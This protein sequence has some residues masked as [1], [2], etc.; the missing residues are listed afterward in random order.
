MIAFR[1]RQIS[2]R[3]LTAFTLVAIAAMCLGPAPRGASQEPAIV[4]VWPGV[5]P[6]SENRTGPESVR[7]TE[8]GD[9]VVTNVHRP[10]LTVYLPPADRA[11][12]AGVIVMPGGGHRELW[13][14]HEGHTVARWL[15]DRGVA[16]FVLKYRLAREAGSTYAIEQH[17]LPDA[18]RALRLV[19]S[20]SAEW[21]VT[22]DRVGVMGFSAGGE[23]AALTA[24]KYDEGV[25]SAS[26]AVERMGSKPAF[27]ALIYPGR[28]SSIQPAKDS[29]PAFL[30]AGFDDRPDISEGLANVY[31]LFK[32]AGVQSELHIFSGVGH[33]FGLRSRLRGPVAGW[34]Q[35]FLEWLGERGL[36][37]GRS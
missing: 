24:M 10:T 26:D 19:R 17:A 5:P 33:G 28:S 36:L 32:K 31:R 4:E 9:H 3:R 34:P 8:G 22:P 12:G 35:R 16:A 37:A 20:R 2:M 25:A 23:V 11:S 7:V 18:Q 13:V 1:S 21:R 6:G 27:Q 15:S 30:V 14:D 29:P